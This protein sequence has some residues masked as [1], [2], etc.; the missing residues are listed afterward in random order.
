MINFIIENQSLIKSYIVDIDEEREYNI[1]KLYI[2]QNE[3]WKIF[4]IPREFNNQLHKYYK[5][6]EENE[7]YLTIRKDYVEYTLEEI[8]FNKEILKDV[9][10]YLD[11]ILRKGEKVD[12][13]KSYWSILFSDSFYDYKGVLIY[14]HNKLIHTYFTKKLELV[15]LFDEQNRIRMVNICLL[16]P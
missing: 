9:N 1:E 2:N 10:G 7:L 5:D 16:I 6:L 8:P 4:C 12:T 11:S 13:S 15:F 14:N 3:M